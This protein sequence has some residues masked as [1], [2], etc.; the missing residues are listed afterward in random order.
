[1]IFDNFGRHFGAPRVTF[2]D[3]VLKWGSQVPQ[4]KKD[5]QRRPISREV[6]IPGGSLG[7]TR[8]HLFLPL[9]LGEDTCAAFPEDR[10]R[11]SLRVAVVSGRRS[12]DCAGALGAHIN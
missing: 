2:R 5:Q 1:M 6:G 10:R 4:S 7:R 8:Q 9:A 3:S 12:T 11:R